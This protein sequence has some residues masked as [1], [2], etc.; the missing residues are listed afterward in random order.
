MVGIREMDKGSQMGQFTVRLFTVRQVK[1]SVFWDVVQE[2]ILP[3]IQI[4]EHLYNLY[5][6]DLRC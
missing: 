3:H 1:A 4:T 2:F 5:K 6:Y